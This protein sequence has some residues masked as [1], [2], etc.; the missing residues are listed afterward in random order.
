MV[1]L[2][3]AIKATLGVGVRKEPCAKEAVFS[4]ISLRHCECGCGATSICL[5]LFSCGYFAFNLPSGRNLFGQVEETR[6]MVRLVFACVRSF[7]RSF[8]IEGP[9]D[10]R[11]SGSARSTAGNSLTFRFLVLFSKLARRPS[12]DFG[13]KF[14]PLLPP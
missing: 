13:R 9:N 14:R 4:S 11:K 3:S 7:V 10:G 12:F 6:N 5:L 2:A 8:C 1:A